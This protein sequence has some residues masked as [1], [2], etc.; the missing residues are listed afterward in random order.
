MAKQAKKAGGKGKGKARKL[1]V[2]KQAIRDLEPRPGRDVVGGYEP[3][4]GSKGK[5]K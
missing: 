2:K 3:P 4:L 5:W 1:G